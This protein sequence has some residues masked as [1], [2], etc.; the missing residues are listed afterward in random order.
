VEEL[1]RESVGEILKK[2]KEELRRILGDKFVKLILFGSFARG[3]YK[4]GSDIDVLLVVK[5]EPT[6]EEELKISLLT[7]DMSLTHDIVISCFTYP[8]DA[9]QKWE[10]PFL[11]NIRREGINI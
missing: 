8:Y 11:M 10:T 1:T 6:E 7:T 4:F 9:F 2:F 5:E 3:D